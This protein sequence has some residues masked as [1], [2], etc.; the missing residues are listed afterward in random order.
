MFFDI[1]H[2]SVNPNYKILMSMLKKS[3]NISGAQTDNSK[4]I[5]DKPREKFSMP[6]NPADATGIKH[7]VNPGKSTME[8]VENLNK[9]EDLYKML[10]AIKRNMEMDFY[11]IPP[12]IYIR[13]DL[14]KTEKKNLLDE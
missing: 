8:R 4:S 11:A 5:A 14:D 13:S 2:Q 3:S 7:A 12:E 10:S 9:F 1:R 6:Q